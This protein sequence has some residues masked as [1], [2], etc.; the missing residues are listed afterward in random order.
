MA[1]EFAYPM[2]LV[3]EAQGG[4]L[5]TCPD[6]PELLT[7]GED[8]EAARSQA[9]DALEEVVAARMRLEDDIPEASDPPA[10]LDCETVQL[11]PLMSAKAAFYLAFREAGKSR[12]SF[13]KQ[14]GVDEKE[15]RRLLNPRHATKL[16]RLEEA[17]NAL[18]GCLQIKFMAPTT[19]ELT[20]VP[21]AA[22]RHLESDAEDLAGR[23]FADEVS[24]GGAIPIDSALQRLSEIALLRNLPSIPVFVEDPALRE[25]GVTE[26]LGGELRIRLRQDVAENA[27]N[28][29]GRSRFTAAHELGHAILHHRELATVNGH[30][31]R[32]QRCT[33]IEK[34]PC[35]ARIYE[36][37]DWQANSWAGAFLMPYAA[38]SAFLRRQ[39]YKDDFDVDALASN[40]LVSSQVARIRVE[41]LLPRLV[42]GQKG[43]S[44]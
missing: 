35:G 24:A 17:L 22:Y 37:P 44:N 38:V 39:R 18:G 12:S 36:S 31:F 42:A 41:K 34:L 16:S 20:R 33:P 19:V 5:V 26:Y 30:A 27:R 14:L 25:E 21:A 3:E 9:A 8:R 40:F 1:R 11:S 43:G 29:V 2:V 28:G 6:F 4:Y 13:A 23:L 15:V 7:E 10:G 32:D